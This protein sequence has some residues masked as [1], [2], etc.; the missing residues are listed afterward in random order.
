V[1]RHD[2]QGSARTWSPFKG[3]TLLLKATLPTCVPSHRGLS[4]LQHAPWSSPYG[5]G[6]GSHASCK[7]AQSRRS[8]TATC[9]ACNC[10]DQWVKGRTAMQPA[11][12]RAKWAHPSDSNTPSME[13]Q[14]HKSCNRRAGCY[15]RA[16]APP[17]TPLP[18][19]L[20][21]GT[22]T[23]T[24]G[25]PVYD[26]TVPARRI[27]HGPVSRGRR[28]D[29]RCGQKWVGSNGG[30]GRAEAVSRRQP[31]SRHLVG[32]RENP[33]PRREDDAPVFRSS[34]G[35]RTRND[36]PAN[37]S[38]RRINSAAGQVAPLAGEASNASPSP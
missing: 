32:Q 25:N 6:A 23:A 21:C 22:S 2:A 3:V 34:N 20:D 24:R 29:G 19:L 35:S 1:E 4:L 28:S 27:G 10:P 11:C 12:N 36:C 7:V 8:Q 13:A 18:R 9:G 33:L 30:G 31:S 15:V 17:L 26:P 37:H 16:T 5:A 38:P 14:A